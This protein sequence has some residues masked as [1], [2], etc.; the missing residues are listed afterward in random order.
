[1]IAGA[2]WW[3]DRTGREHV[4]FLQFDEGNLIFEYEPL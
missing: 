3:C 4:G 1:M 2:G